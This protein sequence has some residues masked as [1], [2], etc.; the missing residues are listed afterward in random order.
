MK[1][2]AVPISPSSAT[3]RAAV[4]GIVIFVAVVGLGVVPAPSPAGAT[5]AVAL[6]GSGIGTAHFGQTQAVVISDLEHSLGPSRRFATTKLTDDCNVDADLVWPTVTVFFD[7]RH[8]VGYGYTTLS[9]MGYGT[10]H[11]V[12]A[13]V[14][15]SARGLRIGDTVRQA[16]RIY[17]ADFH[18]ST[19]QSGSWF[20]ITSAGRLDGLLTREPSP[21]APTDR[22]ATIGAGDVGC[23]ATSP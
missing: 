12:R 2:S 1:P 14:G 21:N 16:R 22:I 9:N 18:I 10:G 11:G 7:H 5:D 17:K 15:V 13:P 3:G 6:N 20:A 23:P 4:R 19:T 8:F